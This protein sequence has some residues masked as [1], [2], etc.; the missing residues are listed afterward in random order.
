VRAPPGG[1]S[2]RKEMKPNGPKAAE[3]GAM[4]EIV[5]KALY[6]FI[7]LSVAG[8]C[9]HEVWLAW[10]DRTVQYGAFAA[11][12]DGESSDPTG[13]SFRRLIVQQQRRLFRLYQPDN[14]SSK[15]GEFRAPGDAIHIQ[16]VRD[17][18]DIP[19]SL[20]D[21]LKLEAA[22][23]NVSS[24][25]T[26]LR[27][28]VRPPN[29]ITGSVDQIGPAIYVTANWAHSPRRE[30]SG[31]EAR[32]FVLPPQAGLEAASFDVASRIFLTRI[33]P[34]DD[35]WKQVDENDFCAFSR[36][37]ASFHDYVDA[38]NGALTDDDRKAARDGPLTKARLEIDR[39]VLNATTL[40]YA[41][42][43]GGYID[44][45][46]IGAVPP[47]D[48]AEPQ[49]KAIL[50]QAEARFNDYLQRLSKIKADARD[51]DAQ[52]RIAYLAARRGLLLKTEQV[53][54]NTKE[55]L[56]AYDKEKGAKPATAEQPASSALVPGASIGPAGEA[57]AGTLCC[58]VKDASGKKYLVTANHIAGKPGT[59]V[60]WPATIDQAKSTAIGTVTRI[61]GLVALVEIADG[62]QPG[63]GGIDG[64]AGDVKVGDTVTM[65]GRTSKS[66]SGK[67]TGTGASF[68]FPAADGQTMQE[69]AILTDRI[70]SAGDGGAPV[71]DANNR[72]VGLLIA[73]SQTSSVV[74]PLKPILDREGLSLL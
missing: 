14:K 55:F 74:L 56:G 4:A 42:K 32:V 50:D 37:L 16:N 19:K 8:F 62:V 35:V 6:T 43:L 66:V 21:D 34:F 33:A 40:V 71:L 26:T 39:L 13:N 31:T 7:L 1:Y 51:E 25:L 3:A 23:V 70:S 73:R 52:E 28:W 69:G 64:W 53:A 57:I 36:A 65:I 38:R 20:L 29:E 2:E 45:E 30:G 59:Q 27:R 17:L 60:V 49:I 22:G 18:G 54:A 5:A 9:V 58:F 46:R 24:V 44:I 63:N 12:K 48:G 68:P 15:A 41:Y 72:L 10:F 11:S 61:L 67:V 47:G